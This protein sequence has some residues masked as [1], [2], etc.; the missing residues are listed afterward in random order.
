MSKDILNKILEDLDLYLKENPSEEITK[1]KK[2][3]EKK[4][5][6]NKLIDDIYDYA[7]NELSI[8]GIEPHTDEYQIIMEFISQT[9]QLDITE[10]KHLTKILNKLIRGKPLSPI[11]GNPDEW[12]QV[13]EKTL[14]NN[15][16]NELFKDIKTN[17]ASYLEAIQWHD[18]SRKIKFFGDVT[19]V[20]SLNNVYTFSSTQKV[21]FPF[22]PK[23]FTVKIKRLDSGRYL[24]KDK[25][26]FKKALNYYKGEL[27]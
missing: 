13:D 6:G 2:A 9:W 27:K 20:F 26:T 18:V 19:I 3:L 16:C 12:V 17:E 14:Q 1:L 5:Y 21:K 25:K 22:N 24:L 4:T 7:L 8:I 11:T 15:R 23:T 10:R